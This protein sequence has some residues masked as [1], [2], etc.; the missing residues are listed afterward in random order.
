MLNDSLLLLFHNIIKTFWGVP[1]MSQQLL[2]PT[3]IHE[4]AGSIP[5]LVQWVKDPVL[6]WAVVK[7]ADTAQIQSCCGCGVG[8]QLQLQLDPQPRNLHMPQVQP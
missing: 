7:V 5:V 4:D 3:R 8:Q 1:V 2:N 6:L